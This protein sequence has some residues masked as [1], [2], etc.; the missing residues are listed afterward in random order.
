METIANYKLATGERRVTT[1][2]GSY[3]ATED[4]SDD[5]VIRVTTDIGTAPDG[6]GDVYL[7]FTRVVR[8]S[9]GSTNFN[10]FSDS[11][12]ISRAHASELV[13]VL[14]KALETSD[15]L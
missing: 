11:A 3:I 14:T 6:S 2:D 8:F 4:S 5:G 12:Y 1:V 13:A 7:S 9:D 15:I 10:G